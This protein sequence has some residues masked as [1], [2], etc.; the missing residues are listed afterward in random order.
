MENNNSKTFRDDVKLPPMPTDQDLVSIPV[1]NMEEAEFVGE[2][3]VFRNERDGIKNALSDGFFLLKIPSGVDFEGGDKF[4]NN[5][6]KDKDNSNEDDNQYKGYRDINLPDTY[7]GYFDREHD[8]WENFYIEMTNWKDFLP[9][10]VENVGHK[11]TDIGINIL[12]NVLSY[13]EVP[14]SKWSNLTSGLSEKKGH[15]MLAFN[16]FRSDKEVR[17]SKF[18]RDSGWVTV[19]RSTEPGLVAYIRDALYSIVPKPGYLVINFGSSIE[20]LTSKLNTKVRANI[21]GVVRTLRKSRSKDRTS[22]V[23]FLDSNL[24]GN[25]YVLQDPKSEEFVQTVADFAIQEVNRTYDE[26]NMIL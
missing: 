1:F 4:V 20:V 23:V 18:H 12:R 10:K 11:M 13:L 17:G 14:E 16:H 24:A 25:I 7:Q 8:Q 15:Q 22:Y 6:F 21:H 3:L 9:A 2:K 5:F 19:L 26:D